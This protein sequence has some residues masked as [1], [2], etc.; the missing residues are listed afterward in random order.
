M[1][2]IFQT[3]IKYIKYCKQTRHLLLSYA[4]WTQ[5]SKSIYISRKQGKERQ[6][7]ENQNCIHCLKFTLD[8]LV[9]VDVYPIFI[10][11][12]SNPVPIR[13]GLNW[14]IFFMI[15]LYTIGTA[16]SFSRFLTMKHKR[17][18]LENVKNLP[19]QICKHK[20]QSKFFLPKP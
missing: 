20:W 11:T 17:K 9:D 10:H 12:L 8:F 13:K 16:N 3:T 14:Q 7:N 19:D 4:M 1:F 15:F 6:K 18:V 2:T 5:S